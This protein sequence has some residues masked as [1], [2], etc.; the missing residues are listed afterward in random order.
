MAR[1]LVKL[2]QDDRD[3]IVIRWASL[4]KEMKA[5]SYEARPIVELKGMCQEFFDGY[6]QMLAKGDYG[7]LRE[8]IEKKARLRTSMGFKLSEAQ[9]ALYTIKEVIL[10]FIREEYG[11]DLGRF[12]DALQRIDSCLIKTIFDFSEAYQHQVRAR[13][14]EYLADIEQFNRRLEHLSI[15]DGL[16]G[17]Y[18]HKYF[19]DVLARELKRAERYG[20][21]LSLLIFDIDNFKSYN[22]TYGHARGDE[23]I[24]KIAEILQE[25]TRV[26]DLAARYG[27]EEFVLVLPETEAREARVVA[28]KV[29]KLVES[30]SFW[31][32]E[33]KSVKISLSAGVSEATEY[34]MDKETLIEQADRAMYQAKKKG[35]NKVSVFADVAGR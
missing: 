29:R 19:Q 10:P 13:M 33:A 27:G 20:R 16:T 21:P 7:P 17:L 28:E 3:E 9:R 2:L 11:D 15:T 4:L 32:G 25:E 30:H 5:T 8:F 35:K 31:A 24:Q 34:P 26:V 18:N 12:D 1:G 22:D 6:I 14:H 23:V